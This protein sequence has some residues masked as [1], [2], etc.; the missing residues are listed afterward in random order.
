MAGANFRERARRQ[1]EST[2]GPPQVLPTEVGSLYRWV[3]KRP[4]GKSLYI[5]LDS[6]EMTHIAHVL[7]SDPLSTQL[8][9]ISSLVMR[10]DAEVESAIARI[11]EQH[12][13]ITEA[14]RG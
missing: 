5:T 10:T 6:P 13:G 7:V 9:P 4:S 1:F 3:L 12:A 8:D 11:K 14:E 2:F